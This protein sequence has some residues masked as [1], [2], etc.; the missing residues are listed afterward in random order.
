VALA[1][2]RIPDRVQ[3]DHDRRLRP[4]RGDLGR[5]LAQQ[6]SQL[7]LELAHA[8]L[9]GVLGGHGLQQLIGDLDLLGP[10]PVALEL[11][12]PQIPARDRDLLGG[13]V[14]VEADDLHPVEQR[15][16]NCVGQVRRGDEHHA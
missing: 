14:A 9:S 6:R 2:E 5:G 8:R 11:T 4:A 3:V 16:G 10:Q 1:S 12:R 15:P 13:G 7:A